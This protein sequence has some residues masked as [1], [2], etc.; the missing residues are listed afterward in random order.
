M[1]NLTTLAPAAAWVC[2]L[3]ITWVVI[4]PAMISAPSD[5]AVLGGIVLVLFSTMLAVTNLFVWLQETLN[6]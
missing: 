2:F 5:L 4:G 1:K 6:D 3:L